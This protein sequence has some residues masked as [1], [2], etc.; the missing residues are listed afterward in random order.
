M[1]RKSKSKKKPIQKIVPGDDRHEGG[2]GLIDSQAGGF[3]VF[4]LKFEVIGSGCHGCDAALLVI[5]ALQIHGF[6]G[7]CHYFAQDDLDAAPRAYEVAFALAGYMDDGYPLKERDKILAVM[8][9]QG[10]RTPLLRPLKA[11]WRYSDLSWVRRRMM[12]RGSVVFEDGTPARVITGD[13][14]FVAECNQIIF[15]PKDGQREP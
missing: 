5:K 12:F 6:N 9:A 10:R 15:S 1:P 14:W 2:E 11:V 4:Y 7:T 8:L 13:S 3:P